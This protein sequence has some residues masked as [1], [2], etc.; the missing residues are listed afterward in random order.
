MRIE[1]EIMVLLEQLANNQELG[2]SIS[3]LPVTIY[4]DGTIYPYCILTDET[5]DYLSVIVVNEE[6]REHAKVLTKA[7]IQSIEILYLDQ[8]LQHKKDKASG[9]DERAYG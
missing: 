4:L 2:I 1:Q 9:G 7:Y 6:G 8:V 5:E 3:E